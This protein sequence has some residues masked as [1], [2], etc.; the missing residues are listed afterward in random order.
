MIGVEAI[1]GLLSKIDSPPHIDSRRLLLSS[2]DND[3]TISLITNK[4]CNLG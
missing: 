1:S 3:E 4:F 2:S